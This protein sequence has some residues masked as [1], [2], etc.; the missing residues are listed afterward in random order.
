LLERVAEKLGTKN[1]AFH[2]DLVAHNLDAAENDIN[3]KISGIEDWI[4]LF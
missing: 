1:I 3:G 4:L 2:D